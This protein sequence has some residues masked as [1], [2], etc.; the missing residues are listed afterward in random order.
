VAG[1][2]EISVTFWPSRQATRGE[3]VTG[4]WARFVRELLAQ[5]E[6]ASVKDTLPGWSAATFEGNRRSGA[7]V[8]HVHAL[9]LDHDDGRASLAAVARVW[10]GTLGAIH[11]T[12]RHTAKAPRWRVVIALSRPVTRAEH[13]RLWAWAQARNAQAGHVLDSRARDASRFW[14]VPARRP[15]ARYVLRRLRGVPLDVDAVLAVAPP[16]AVSRSGASG[17]PHT[18]GPRLSRRDDSASGEDAKL[19]IKLVQRGASDEEIEQA[20][21]RSAERKNNPSDYITRTIGWARAFHERGL[22]RATITRASLQTL[23]ARGSKAMLVRWLLDV[24]TDDGEVL[25]AQVVLPTPGYEHADEAFR[26]V[27]PRLRWSDR[28]ATIEGWRG[29]GLLPLRGRVLDVA[30][31][32]GRVRW[33]RAAEAP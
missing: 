2:N 5:P 17:K 9:G 6:V 12:W 27:F 4:P 18:G 1:K 32:G 24:T 29:R 3:R 31:H 26:A 25:P 15:R 22:V 33:I 21:A 23:P 20:L 7:R 30:A 11:S 16:C 28:L 14:Y 10:R 19:A 8:E 13:A